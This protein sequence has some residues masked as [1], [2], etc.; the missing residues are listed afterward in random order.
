MVRQ[1]SA[2][3]DSDSESI[4]GDEDNSQ[5]G[6]GDYEYRSVFGHKIVHELSC[7]YCTREL[8]RRGMRALLLADTDVELFS[9]DG[10]P[11]HGCALIGESY[12]TRQCQC[13]ISDVAC[14]G[15]G[16][17]VGYHVVQPCCSCL[18][19]CNNGHLWMFH[20]HAVQAQERA[21]NRNTKHLTW[22][23]L[24]CV[25]EDKLHDPQVEFLNAVQCSR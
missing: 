23:H 8:S 9:T 5:Y 18:K 12:S 17:I 16:N 4:S 13:V 6:Q 25:H 2:S 3:M 15:C 20:G 14:L 19:A 7:H 10:P 21:N 1:R 11:L 22:S 24:P